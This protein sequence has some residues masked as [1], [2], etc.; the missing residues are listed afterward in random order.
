MTG[1]IKVAAVAADTD[2]AFK[3]C[4]HFTRY[5]THINDEHVETAE[6]LDIVM[7]MYNLIEYSNNHADSS[8]SLYQFKRDESP[9]NNTGNPSNV[10]L[11]NSTFFKYKAS[12]LRKA[13]D[14]DGNDRSLKSTKIVVPLKYLSNFFRSLEMPLINCK[15]HLELNWNNDCVIYGADTYAGGDIDNDRETTFQIAQNCLF[16]L[17]L[18]QLNTMNT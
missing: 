9:M 7:P 16:Q 2:V 1:D 4:A 17:L 13:T 14:A 12:L 5:V 18:Y 3:N 15:I 6:N 10:A 8:G 11:H